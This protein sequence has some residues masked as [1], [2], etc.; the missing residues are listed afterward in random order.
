[1]EEIKK[2]KKTVKRRR[3][4]GRKKAGILTNI[5][6]VAAIAVFCVSAYQLY[7]IFKGYYDGRSEYDNIRSSR[8]RII[9]NICIRP[10]LQMRIRWGRSS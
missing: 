9:R 5:I 7:K 6:L 1:M 10:S 8:G 3:R 4:R 2:S